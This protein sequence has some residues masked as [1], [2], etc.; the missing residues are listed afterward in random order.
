M[1]RIDFRVVTAATKLPVS[2]EEVLAHLEITEPGDADELELLTN[3]LTLFIGAA[4]EAYE[5]HANRTIHETVYDAVLQEWPDTNYIEL[6]RAAPLVSVASVTLKDSDELETLWSSS[7]WIADTNS[8]PGR[9]MPRYNESWPDFTPSPASPI[10]IR[11]TA[12][13]AA[14]PEVEA[15]DVIKQPIL[16]MVSALYENREAET[17]LTHT[18]NTSSLLTQYGFR[19]FRDLKRTKFSF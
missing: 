8:E 17:I 16:M 10:K 14:S 12:G 4:R 9:L 19:F 13:L 3:K 18:A 6:P 1:E 7:E 15:A 11:Y 2:I 5:G